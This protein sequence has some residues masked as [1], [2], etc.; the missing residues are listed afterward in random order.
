MSIE[1]WWGSGSPPAWRVL[2]GLAAKGLDYESHLLSFSEGDLRKPEFR[3]LN[4]RGKVPVVREG[5]LTLHE[6]L[7]ILAWLDKRSPEPPLFGRTAEEHGL[8]WMYCLEYENHGAPAFGAVYRP[9]LS[10]KGESEA[11]AIRAAAP[12]MHGEL[13]RLEAAVARG[14]MVGEELSAADLVWFVGLQG[15]VRAATRPAA[16][17]LELGLLPLGERYPSLLAWA[18]RIESLPGYDRAFPPHWLTSDPPSPRRLS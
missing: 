3:A 13:A 1:V 2:L 6:S 9:L 15:L 12:L 8:V 7:A 4:P 5:E 18:R 10:G 17:P 16:R 11:D 14:A